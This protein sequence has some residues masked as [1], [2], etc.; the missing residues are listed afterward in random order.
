MSARQFEIK[1][2]YSG[3]YWRCTSLQYPTKLHISDLPHLL[4]VG[5]VLDIGSN[6]NSEIQFSILGM[7]GE[8]KQ[9]SN[10]RFLRCVSRH[11]YSNKL[12]SF[13]WLNR[14]EGTFTCRRTGKLKKVRRSS[15]VPNGSSNW[16]AHLPSL[17]QVLPHRN[18]SPQTAN[19]SFGAYLKP[20]GSQ[21]AVTVPIFQSNTK[22][23]SLYQEHSKQ[24][25]KG[26]KDD[27]CPPNPYIAFRVTKGK[28]YLIKHVPGSAHFWKRLVDQRLLKIGLIVFR[29]RKPKQTMLIGTPESSC[30]IKMEC[31]GLGGRPIEITYDSSQGWTIIHNARLGASVGVFTSPQVLSKPSIGTNTQETERS[32]WMKLYPGFELCV[33]YHT[34]KVSSSSLAN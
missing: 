12:S 18:S 27:S 14:G 34:F 15:M 24:L 13:F 20:A 31:P 23:L 32:P 11:E 26:S 4:E 22:G 10:H 17:T 7:S 28:E 33:G 9:R 25:R 29:T 1:N 30:H 16:S 19:H 21:Q 8:P 3:W 2:F 6:I 5:T